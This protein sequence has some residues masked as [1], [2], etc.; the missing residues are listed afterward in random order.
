MA[1]TSA[2]NQSDMTEG[3]RENAVVEPPGVLELWTRDALEL[4]HAFERTGDVGQLDSAIGLFTAVAQAS[5]G[6]HP[7]RSRYLDNCGVAFL[8]RFEESAAP[9]DLRDALA[10]SRA[11]TDRA[12]ISHPDD[13]LHLSNRCNTALAWFDETGDGS[14]LDEAIVA[15]C[16]AVESAPPE[17]PQ[18]ELYVSNL[19]MARI[20]RFEQQTRRG[21]ELMADLQHELA[22]AVLDRAIEAYRSAVSDV[23]D[24]YPQRWL[25]Q[26]NLS[27]ALRRRYELL[28]EDNDLEGSIVAARRAL[29]SAGPGATPVPGQAVPPASCLINLS[30]ALLTRFI[31]HAQA[32]DA[33]EV[34]EIGRHADEVTTSP[35]DRAML[36]SNMVGALQGRATLAP[37]DPAS[38]ADLD[39]A[40]EASR[41]LVILAQTSADRA[42]YQINLAN[43]LMS[44]AELNPALAD[45][46]DAIA[47][48]AAA[49]GGLPEGSQEWAQATA[50]L[51]TARIRR[52][53]ITGSTRDTDQAIE[54]WLK[55]A[56]TPSVSASIRLAAARDASAIAARTGMPDKAKVVAMTA[57]DL[58]S[59]T[60]W[61]GLG[62]QSRARQL[63]KWSGTATE[64]T[65][66]AV[67]AGD[68]DTATTLAEQG[69]GVIW[70]QLLDLRAENLTSL[71]DTA[72]DLA[73]RLR[74]VARELRS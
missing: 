70:R 15:G 9:A 72:P 24:D 54:H 67:S 65:A 35:G 57:I 39:E 68:A 4:A 50:N 7:E 53:A 12:L 25:A 74:L 37:G 55:I 56:T 6:S 17:D 18:M 48:A 61:H 40:V 69:R 59:L 42:A 11:A 71:Q 3:A 36:V 2:S 13:A 64:A 29:E 20:R 58:L 62:W 46:S 30:A 49:V 14:A 52:W 38:G 60:A 16:N 44:R 8:T 10:F 41:D 43:S 28:S 63:S 45:L 1:S 23:P 66:Y 32:S 27:N 73:R 19:R 22:P 21:I 51:A 26:S 31:A 5:D 47:Q 33:D 34:I